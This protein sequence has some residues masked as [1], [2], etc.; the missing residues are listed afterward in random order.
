MPANVGEYV[1]QQECSFTA[2]ENAEWHNH[3]RGQFGSF[4]QN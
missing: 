4:L 2:V 1:E 3:Y